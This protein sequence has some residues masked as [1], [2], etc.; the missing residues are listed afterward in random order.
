MESKQL[1]NDLTAR[2]PELEWKINELGS[3]FS[4]YN[5]PKGLFRSKNELDG[6]ACIAEIK[7]DIHALSL[8]KNERS[9]NYLAER[10][11]Q[12]VNVL[13]ALCQILSR[14]PKVEDKSCFGVKMLSTRQQWIRD[15]E[16]KIQAMEAQRQAMGRSLEQ[17]MRRNQQPEAILQLKAE[18]GKIEQRITVAQETLSRAVS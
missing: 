11:L 17:M 16:V 18:L 1:L 15:L 14:K 12:K 2:L 13:V 3:A 5:L 9:A 6:P 8:Q 4:K 7:T 10:I